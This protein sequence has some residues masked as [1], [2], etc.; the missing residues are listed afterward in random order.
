MHGRWDELIASCPGPSET[1]RGYGRPQ[2]CRFAAEAAGARLLQVRVRL[3]GADPALL[4]TAGLLV[5]PAPDRLVQLPARRLYVTDTLAP[6]RTRGLPLQIE[7]MARSLPT[8]SAASTTANLWT[9]CSCAPDERDGTPEVPTR[10]CCLHGWPGTPGRH[11][12]Q[13]QAS[14]PRA[15]AGRRVHV[16]TA[17]SAVAVDLRARPVAGRSTRF[18]CGSEPR[19]RP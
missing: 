16:G 13:R 7:S 5:G 1:D 17:P 14:R 18:E 8:P 10:R 9:P 11:R 2:L 19:V 4:G 3:T 6:D 12:Q 15:Y